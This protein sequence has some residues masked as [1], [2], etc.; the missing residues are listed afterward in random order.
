MVFTA[1]TNSLSSLFFS[2]IKDTLKQD[3]ET[4]EHLSSNNISLEMSYCTY[5]A[6]EPMLHKF[7]R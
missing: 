6:Y 2:Q 5:T 3:W 1:K 7:R 4:D